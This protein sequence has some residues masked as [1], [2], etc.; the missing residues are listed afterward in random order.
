MESS[1]RTEDLSQSCRQGEGAGQESRRK[2]KAGGLGSASS[3]PSCSLFP[4]NLHAGAPCL[5]HVL[6]SRQETGGVISRE[7]SHPEI[8]S[9]EQSDL[10]PQ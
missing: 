9:P 3:V 8:D 7:T 1:S 2:G 5:R 6:L 4:R 10:G